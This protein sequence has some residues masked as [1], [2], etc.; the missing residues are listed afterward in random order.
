MTTLE[1]V[2]L[3]EEKVEGAVA[4]IQQLQAENDALRKRCA[5]LTNAYSSQSEQ[6]SSFSSDKSEIEDGIKKALDRLSIIEN[7]AIKAGT[8]QKSNGQAAI[9]TA[10]VQATK[11]PSAPVQPTAMV[12]E[13]VAPTTKPIV[14][15]KAAPASIQITPGVSKINEE[16]LH[17]VQQFN[18]V[19]RTQVSSQPVNENKPTNSVSQNPT[20]NANSQGV[21]QRQQPSSFNNYQSNMAQPSINFD[22]MELSSQFEEDEMDD[23]NYDM[24]SSE[25]FDDMGLSS[26]FDMINEAPSQFNRQQ[27]PNNISEDPNKDNHI[28]Y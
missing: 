18:S 2:H 20:F 8:T 11:K 19:N 1:Q 14:E 21:Q 5:E 7:A 4:K 12:E 10:T 26:S 13:K 6:L 22:T 9:P 23:D 27:N 16:E 24:D 28:I 15:K 25:S 3:L 17:K